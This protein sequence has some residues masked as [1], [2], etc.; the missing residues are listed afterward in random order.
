MKTLTLNELAKACNFEIISAGDEKKL[1]TVYNRYLYDIAQGNSGAFGNAHEKLTRRHA[2]H[3]T[4]VAKWGKADITVMIDG[5]LTNAEAK[6]NGGRIDGINME[7]TVYTLCVHNSQADI[8][9][10]PK[11]MR[12]ETFI[13]ALYDMG[14]VKQVRHG[15][16]VDGI[17]IQPLSRKLWAWLDEQLDYDASWEYF[18][19]DFE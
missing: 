18:S 7:Y 10:Q 15:G 5:K 2:S 19:E 4:T 11:V 13:N 1:A 17:A 9:I 12:T 3:K 14:A 6:T 16:V 8:D